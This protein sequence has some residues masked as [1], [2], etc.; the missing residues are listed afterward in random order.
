MIIN[1]PL[2]P[3]V[4]SMENKNICSVLEFLCPNTSKVTQ[5]IEQMEFQTCLENSELLYSNLVTT[6]KDKSNR[7]C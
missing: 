1:Y 5:I 6:Y 2:T 4:S 3:L 7:L